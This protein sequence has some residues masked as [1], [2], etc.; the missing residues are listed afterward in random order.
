MPVITGLI[1]LA[2]LGFTFLLP[3]TAAPTRGRDGADGEEDG[4]NDRDGAG[5]PE[6]DGGGRRQEV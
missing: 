1:L 6:P 2:G 3:R 5:T 4:E